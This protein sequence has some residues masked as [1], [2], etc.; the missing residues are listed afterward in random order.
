MMGLVRNECPIIA[1]GTTERRQLH[2]DQQ[3]K[4]LIK[5]ESTLTHWCGL[6]LVPSSH[7]LT[8]AL[9]FWLSYCRI[10]LRIAKG[11]LHFT[12][13]RHNVKQT[14]SSLGHWHWVFYLQPVSFKDAKMCHFNDEW[15]EHPWTSC[16]F[17]HL[18]R[19]IF[20]LGFII[21]LKFHE[22]SVTPKNL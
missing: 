5:E 2:R 15:R 14:I 8:L 6:L 7:D 20:Y 10:L 16:S 17:L 13:G 3:A 4:T 12:H 11:S 18:R 9:Q 1:S 21:K 19:F 22:F